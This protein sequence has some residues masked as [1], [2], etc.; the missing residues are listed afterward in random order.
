MVVAAVGRRPDNNSDNSFGL[1]L[2]DIGRPP[3]ASR[4]SLAG[5]SPQ[6]LA[7]DY[8]TDKSSPRLPTTFYQFAVRLLELIRV[9]R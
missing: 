7:F 8:P 2:E 1:R 9:V 5:R 4:G 3:L 6:S